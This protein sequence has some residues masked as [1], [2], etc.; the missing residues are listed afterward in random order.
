MSYR[1]KQYFY[2][3]AF[4]FLGFLVSMLVHAGIEIPTLA[5]VT[6]EAGKNGDNIIWQNWNVIH[7]VVGIT[8]SL[9]GVWLGCVLGRRFWRIL[10]VEKRYGTPR[11]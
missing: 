6:D 10:Y 7:G 4:T 11:W 9:G 8:L 5:L 1:M 2:I 3:G